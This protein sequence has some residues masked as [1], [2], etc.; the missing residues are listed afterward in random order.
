M[1][2]NTRNWRARWLFQHGYSGVVRHRTAGRIKTW[3][4]TAINFHPP[5][6]DNMNQH[7]WFSNSGIIFTQQDGS[8]P[9][10]SFEHD[11]WQLEPNGPL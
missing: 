3:C 5:R 11:R 4:G 8:T 6:N 9:L 1:E 2:T 10:A 7:N